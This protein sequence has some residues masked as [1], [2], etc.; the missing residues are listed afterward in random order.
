MASIF[1]Q[2]FTRLDPTTGLRVRVKNSK[3]SVRYRDCDGVLRQVPGFKDK[4][5]T[6][7]LAAQ[8]EKQSALKAVGV[9]DKFAEHRKRP[10]VEHLADFETSL[11]AKENTA[12]HVD[13]VTKRT[14]RVLD[15]CGFRL[16]GDISAAKFSTWI[17]TRRKEGLAA[18][19]ANFYLSSSKGFFRWLVRSARMP[20]NPFDH[21]GGFN[22]ATDR[23]HDRRALTHDELRRLLAA[24]AGGEALCGVAPEDRAMLYLIA[25]STGL[26][27]NELHTLTV[28]SFDFDAAPATVTVEA[29]NSKHRRRDVLPLREDITAALKAWLAKRKVL[30]LNTA[31]ATLW[32]GTWIRRASAMVRMDLA[33]AQLEYKDASGRVFDFHAFRHT[34]LTNLARA[35][36][37]PKATQSLARHSTITLT[38]DKYSHVGLVDMKKALDALP[39]LTPSASESVALK[40]TGTDGK[41]PEREPDL[42]TL[43]LTLAGDFS[44]RDVAHVGNR[45]SSE[46]NAS[47]SQNPSAERDLAQVD[48]PCRDLATVGA[49]HSTL[50][51]VGIEYRATYPRREP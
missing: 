25:A 45:P 30:S 28:A 9:V 10:L 21:L 7:Q 4:E 1:R 37:H 19:T 16:M 13:H 38:M 33:R 12:K 27:A 17:A 46:E 2:A 35:G 36:A 6:R 14:R 18:Q 40:A 49:P 47:L 23:R 22:V 5:A 42:L 29:R 20:D 48:A 44:C 43:P 15:G 50:Q 41:A 3:W 32:P 11:L 24:A 39:A 51:K 26:R 34:F 8:L 31:E